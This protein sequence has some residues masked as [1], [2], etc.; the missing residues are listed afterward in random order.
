MDQIDTSLTFRVV[1]QNPNGIRPTRNEF[2]FSYGLS[3]CHSLGVRLIAVPETKLN[4]TRAASYNIHRWFHQSWQFSSLAY[5]QTLSDK[6]TSCH[7]PGGTLTVVV[8]RWT[9]RVHSKGQ[10]PFGLGR[11]P[12]VTLRGRQESLI[13]IVPAYRV[14]QSLCQQLV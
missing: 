5:S 13:T 9:S 12:F 3:R 1:A 10:D 2:E 7:K 4:W 11:W 6:F 14:S 8:D